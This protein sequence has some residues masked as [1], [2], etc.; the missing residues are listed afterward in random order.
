[1]WVAK[2]GTENSRPCLFYHKPKRLNEYQWYAFGGDYG[3]P[4][5]DA[6]EFD[7]LTWGDDPV[8]VKL[9]KI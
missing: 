8:E 4:L 2:N 7:G 9:V 1:M 5:Y 6:P 3:F